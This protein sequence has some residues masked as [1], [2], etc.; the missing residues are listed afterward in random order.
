V[1]NA[2]IHLA[3][4]SLALA[5]RVAL[6]AGV[7][8]LNAE[9]VD[10]GQETLGF[11]DAALESLAPNQ[12]DG[13]DQ[14]A[15]CVPQQNPIHGIVNIG[16]QAGRIQKRTLHIH[17]FG[18]DQLLRIGGA[19]AEQFMDDLPD[20]GLRPPSIIALE[21]ALAGH[22]DARQL[23]EAAE[24][25]QQ[26]TVGQAGG[27]PAII[28]GQQQTSDIGPQSSAAV[29]LAVLL[30]LAADLFTLAQPAPQAAFHQ[31]SLQPAGEQQGIDAHQLIAQLAIIHIA[32]NGGQDLRQWQF[33]WDNGGVRHDA[34][35]SSSFTWASPSLKE[36]KR[37]TRSKCKSCA[38]RASNPAST[39][40]F[41]WH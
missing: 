27:K 20:V 6:A 37:P 9:P 36:C 15:G 23:T 30:R 33:K 11:F 31:A 24:P 39:S 32:L 4:G 35:V 12:L 16:G 29:A 13:F 34:R 21:R 40:V 2:L 26:G 25:L 5:L 17:G 7:S 10:A 22:G 41:L 8:H 38:P 14:G 1:P 28:L 3:Q 18:Q 19:Q